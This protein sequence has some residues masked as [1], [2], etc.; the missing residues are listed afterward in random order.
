[1]DFHL[2]M[3]RV[4]FED[5]AE[6][7]VEAPEN[8]ARQLPYLTVREQ[9]LFDF[10]NTRRLRLEQEHIPQSVVRAAFLKLGNLP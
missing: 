7:H 4:T 8:N 5:L 3:D 2:P 1:M 9:E 10:L 6:Y